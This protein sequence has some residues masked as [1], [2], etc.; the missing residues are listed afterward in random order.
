MTKRLFSPL[1]AGL[2]AVVLCP[3]IAG[4]GVVS[5]P[6]V[7]RPPTL[8]SSRSLGAIPSSLH[9]AA[10][11]LDLALG[12]DGKIYRR[13]GRE[14]GRESAWR[15]LSKAAAERVF[16]FLVKLPL[17]GVED[18][19][20][21]ALRSYLRPRMDPGRIEDNPF[22]HRRE[23]GS[24][25][26]SDLGRD[27]LLDIL[28]AED[29]QG[30]DAFAARPGPSA[31]G[32]APSRLSSSEAVRDSMAASGSL[33]AL[34]S[35][36]VETPGRLFDGAARHPVSGF[37]WDAL[38]EERARGSGLKAFGRSVLDGYAV[39]H[40][41][42]TLRVIVAA[43]KPV[44]SDRLSLSG[45]GPNAARERAAILAETGLDGGLIEGSRA[46]VLRALDNLVVLE[47]PLPEA[48]RLGRSLSSR[49][50]PSAPAR[51]YRSAAAAALQNPAAGLLGGQLLPFPSAV[52]GEP[53]AAA[54]GIDGRALTRV[55]A[56]WAAG[57]SGAGTTVGMID[58]GMDLEHPDLR[59]R[60]DDGDYA[61][62]SGEGKTDTVG[63]GTHVSGSIGGSGETSGGLY[64]GTAP[65]TRF[66]V[67]KV[68]GSKGDASE[69][70]ILAA[71]KWME[72][73]K[74]DVLNLSLGGSGEPNRDPIGAMANRM[75][76]RGSILVVASVGN[77][78]P[79]PGSVGSPGNGEYVLTVTGVNRDGRFS[80]FPS[81]GPVRGRDG[82]AYNKPDLSTVTGDIFPPP[83]SGDALRR[84]SFAPDSAG[85]APSDPATCVYGPGI[86]STR[87]GA[88][89]DEACAVAGN[90]GY[91][92]LSGTSMASAMASGIGA[93][94]IGYAKSMGV[95]PRP[96]EV[97]AA[98]METARR[99]EEVPRE[100]QGAGLVDGAL[101][102]EVVVERVRSGLPI[103]NV[104]YALAVRMLT[105]RD[106]AALGAQERY[107]ETALGLLD[108]RAGR[109]VGTELE[110]DAALRS[111]R[112]RSAGPVGRS[113]PRGLGS[114][115]G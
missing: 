23:S 101:L 56:L 28:T 29:G 31:P 89:P 87:S 61:D 77:E 68:F 40:G 10:A 36:R 66:V 90:P 64:K 84:R 32:A 105:S 54:A 55:E 34:R 74:P 67:A 51:L 3:R 106:R 41:A 79:A 94:V 76:V 73:R 82:D 63:H 45:A 46:R 49:G 65:W 102:A 4:A 96:V 109:L 78:G 21:A 86:V 14:P 26:L 80:S 11:L 85:A 33:N 53:G 93:D 43:P 97:K 47:V 22:L 83:S 107:R 95:R 60:I 92:F 100:T 62:F 15:A 111:L 42:D 72:R 13:L 38:A 39:D 104:A 7:P 25:R 115:P 9:R 2:A 112:R 24:W 58:S 1:A 71:M 99:L 98:M 37:D 57:M 19:L 20:A 113:T 88:D 6:P 108:T 48:V 70:S 69:D 12:K 52:V 81:R 35:A 5:G 103:G 27:A 44:R 8:G 50:V 75:M 18:A 114:F 110:M 59:G 17:D 16:A 91:R 30:L